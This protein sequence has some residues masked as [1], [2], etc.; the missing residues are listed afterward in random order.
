MKR[1]TKK[2][3]ITEGLELIAKFMMP[4]LQ[5]IQPGLFHLV[6]NGEDRWYNSDHDFKYN[7]SW[8]C[9]M[10]VINELRE[11]LMDVKQRTAHPMQEEMDKF[12]AIV[13]A[14]YWV[15]INRAFNEVVG[16]IKD[17]S[18]QCDGGN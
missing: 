9:L 8:D 12:D 3:L 15:D 17:Y 5:M 7:Q 6:A 18:S 11:L 13:D 14:L 4:D 2:K 16:Y 1:K 10:P